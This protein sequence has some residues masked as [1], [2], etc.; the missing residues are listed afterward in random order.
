MNPLTVACAPLSSAFA[1]VELFNDPRQ[2]PTYSMAGSTTH[3]TA[4]AK[5]PFVNV[6]TSS[7]FVLNE[8]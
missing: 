2:P 8:R 5:I 4:A 3:Q 6:Q 7:T 1:A